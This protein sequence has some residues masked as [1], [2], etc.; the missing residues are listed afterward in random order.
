MKW[1]NHTHKKWN[2]AMVEYNKQNWVSVVCAEKEGE[3]GRTFL[4]SPEI[5]MDNEDIA[6]AHLI[7]SAPEMIEALIYVYDERDRGVTNGLTDKL[8]R[9]IIEDA[10]GMK[11]Q[12]ILDKARQDAAQ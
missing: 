10:T 6:N 1:M 3:E 11:I 2:A 4:I 7:A 12:D 8:M 9:G 5:G